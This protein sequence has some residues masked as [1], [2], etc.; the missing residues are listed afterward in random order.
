MYFL[1]LDTK[2]ITSNATMKS[3]PSNL[4]NISI[5]N[6]DKF[7]GNKYRF[8]LRSIRILKHEETPGSSLTVIAVGLFVAFGGVLFGY[9]TGTISIRMHLHLL[10]RLLAGPRSLGRNG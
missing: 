4:T 9:D 7:S 1:S 6:T 5:T 10:P 2:Y 3:W 8:S